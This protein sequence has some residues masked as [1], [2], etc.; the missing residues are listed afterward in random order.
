MEKSAF[1]LTGLGAS[2]FRSQLHRY[3]IQQKLYQQ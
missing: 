2:N 1:R 3:N